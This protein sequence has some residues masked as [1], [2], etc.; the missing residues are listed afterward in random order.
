[1]DRKPRLALRY[2]FSVRKQKFDILYVLE[3]GDSGNKHSETWTSTGH[4]VINV[5]NCSLRNDL[6]VHCTSHGYREEFSAGQLA[7][8]ASNNFVP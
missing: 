5:T 3:K 4:A 2:E 1:M 6:D 7:P 8:H